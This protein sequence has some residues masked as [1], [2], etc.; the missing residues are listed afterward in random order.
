MAWDDA[1]FG[2]FVTDTIRMARGELPG[3]GRPHVV[4]PYPPNAELTCIEEVR[5]MPARLGQA[6]LVAELV[7]VARYAARAAERYARR[8]LRDALDYERL[9]SDLSDEE[10]PSDE[11]PD[12]ATPDDAR[13]LVAR[14]LSYYLKQTIDADDDGIALVDATQTE[15]ALVIRLLEAMERDLG[16]D[17]SEALAAQ[18]PACL[19]VADLAEWLALSAGQTVEVNGKKQ[20]VRV[21]FFPWHV[22]LYR[23]RPIFWLLSSENFE[24]G[25]TRLTFRAY[26]HYLRLSPDT[27]PRLVTH[28]LE[29]AIQAAEREWALAS[30][31][32][33]NAEGKA[34]AAASRVASEWLNTVTALKRFREATVSA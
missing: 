28:Y 30:K 8:E 31:Q 18:A 12:C 19:G 4:F 32:A 22:S 34:E 16:R 20:R 17:V 10:E 11:E 33:S 2:R 9:Q 29:P 24:T 6:G 15:P 5:R 25:K 13:D 7:P 14:W 27:L 1:K 26:L 23:N 21:G 3:Y